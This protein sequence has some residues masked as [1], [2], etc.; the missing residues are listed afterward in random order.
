ME[1]AAEGPISKIRNRDAVLGAIIPKIFG[2][3]CAKG[4]KLHGFGGRSVQL[5]D[6]LVLSASPLGSERI[7][8]SAYYGVSQEIA[9]VFSA[10]VNDF[11]TGFDPEFFRYQGGRVAILNWRRG[12]WEDLVMA[13]PTSS[14]YSL[15]QYAAGSIRPKQR[16]VHLESHRAAFLLSRDRIH[17]RRPTARR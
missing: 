9:K 17:D 7:M 13:D 2:I 6:E 8:L 16:D 11:P 15:H 14:R 1:L 10:H 12:R 3:L 4:S 5:T